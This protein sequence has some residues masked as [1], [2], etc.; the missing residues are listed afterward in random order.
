MSKQPSVEPKNSSP[1][2]DVVGTVNTGNLEPV[3]SP[4]TAADGKFF[5]FL[6][7]LEQWRIKYEQECKGTIDAVKE[8]FM[9]LA[10]E[11]D[12]DEDYD[13]IEQIEQKQVAFSTEFAAKI[14]ADIFAE[15]RLNQGVKIGSQAADA[16]ELIG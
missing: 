14:N 2:I 10:Q 11:S 12:M 5:I 16:E 4:F 7:N 15:D 9:D 3:I 8:R 1:P 13:Y 6:T